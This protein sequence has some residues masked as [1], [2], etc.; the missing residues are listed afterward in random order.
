MIV[1]DESTCMVD[2]ARYFVDFLCDESCG[3][4]VPCREGLKQ[5]LYI[6]EDI[7][8]GRGTL[9]QL[10]L[11]KE[12]AG[13]M[14]D[15]SLCGL[16]QTAANPVLSTIRYFEDEYVDHIKKMKC[17]AGVCKALIAFSINAKKCTGCMRCRKACPVGAIKGKKKEP[18]TI[19][20]EKCEKCG[21]CLEVCEYGAVV[22]K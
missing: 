19:Q 6:L 9:E 11:L 21:I 14:R 1:M 17:R 22:R 10:E 7:T 16:G 8:E 2:I 18:H 4:C 5:M 15:T 20:A 12:L 3:K 13:V